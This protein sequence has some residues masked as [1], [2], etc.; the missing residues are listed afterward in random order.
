MN[1]DIRDFEYKDIC[2]LIEM[3]ADE[4]EKKKKHDEEVHKRNEIEAQNKSLLN[5]VKQEN[6]LSRSNK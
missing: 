4:A 6:S 2:L 5:R 3:L 1:F